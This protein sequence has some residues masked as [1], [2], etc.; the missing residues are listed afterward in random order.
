[1]KSTDLRIG[2][3]VSIANPEKVFVG[4]VITN[5]FSISEIGQLVALGER[6]KWWR[7]DEIAP[8]PLTEEWLLKLGF[9]YLNT[10]L[11]VKIFYKSYGVE[12]ITIA[13]NGYW[14]IRAGLKGNSA[15]WRMGNNYPFIN[16]VHQLQNLY[17]SLTGEE[18]IIK[19]NVASIQ[20]II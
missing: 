12:F 19:Q 17:H 6:G 14:T 2:N 8:I 16:S 11:E 15:M 18:L 10:E 13:E 5:E 7:L 3:L 4:E 1:M 9:E 20:S